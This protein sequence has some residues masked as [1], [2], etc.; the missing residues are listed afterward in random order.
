VL[1]HNEFDKTIYLRPR[2]WSELTI[3]SP[4]QLGSTT[5]AIE[6]FANITATSPL[7]NHRLELVIIVVGAMF[8]PNPISSRFQKMVQAIFIVRGASQKAPLKTSKTLS[9]RHER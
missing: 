3:L 7:Q 6:F 8:E 5:S 4:N 2:Y 1:V 9:E